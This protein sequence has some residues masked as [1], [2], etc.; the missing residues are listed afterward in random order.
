MTEGNQC[1]PWWKQD[2]TEEMVIIG[3]LLIA[4]AGFRSDEIAKE[5]SLFIAGGFIGYLKGKAKVE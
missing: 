5:L 3:L 2:W 4:I 1:K